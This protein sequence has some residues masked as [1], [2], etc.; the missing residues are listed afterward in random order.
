MTTLAADDSPAA[1]SP[2]RPYRVA[3][4]TLKP[5]RPSQPLQVGTAIGIATEHSH[6][7]SVSIG[8][9]QIGTN[10]IGTHHNML[11]QEELTVY[12]LYLFL[13]ALGLTACGGAAKGSLALTT[14]TDNTP[15]SSGVCFQGECVG[16]GE[17][18]NSCRESSHIQP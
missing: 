10:E 3:N 5:V 17:V 16:E 2:G 8:E 6:E 18:F 15:C 13:M 4:D 11:W 14:C 12:P 1:L 9:I 7:L